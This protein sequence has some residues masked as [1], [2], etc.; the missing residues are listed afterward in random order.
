MC[1]VLIQLDCQARQPEV[2]YSLGLPVGRIAG[3][4]HYA[5]FLAVAVYLGG[6]VFVL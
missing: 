4:N 3:V 5:C 6:G 2:S 1:L